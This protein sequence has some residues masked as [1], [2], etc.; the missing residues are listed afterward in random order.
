MTK[1]M[2]FLSSLFEKSG[3]KELIQNMIDRGAIIVD[4]RAAHE[5]QSGHAIGSINIPLQ[6]IQNRIE[7]IKGYDK[8]VVLCCATGNRSGKAANYLKTEGIECENGGSWTS[9]HS[10][11]K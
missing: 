11:I 8:P 3:D 5:F 9:V 6:D 1:H 4:V 2:G 10:M 7:Q